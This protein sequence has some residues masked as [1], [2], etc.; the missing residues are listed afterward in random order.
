M[1]ADKEGRTIF[2]HHDITIEHY[3]LLVKCN[4]KYRK[5]RDLYNTNTEQLAENISVVVDKKEKPCNP[6]EQQLMKE[7][8]Q[9]LKK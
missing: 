3:L 6:I 9:F 2:A 7:I 8:T 5:R 4:A 1:L